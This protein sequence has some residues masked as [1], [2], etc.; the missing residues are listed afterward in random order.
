MSFQSRLKKLRLDH[1]LTQ[2]DVADK[3]GITRQA[4]GYYENENSK[5]EPDHATTIKLAEIFEVSTDFLLKGEEFDA[6]LNGL[7][8]NTTTQIAARDGDIS[9]E[10]AVELLKLLLEREK[11]R[12]P[13]DKQSR[14]KNR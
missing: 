7:L 14:P 6:D 13:G 4:Y 12:K 9:D 3:L 11:G 1:K 8:K 10:E 5:R 2:Q